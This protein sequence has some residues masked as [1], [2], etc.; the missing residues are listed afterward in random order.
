MAEMGRYSSNLLPL[1]EHIARLHFL[2]SF[3]IRYRH[4]MEF[5][6]ME[7]REIDLYLPLVWWLVQSLSCV[8]FRENPKGLLCISVK[9]LFLSLP[10]KK[11]WQ[12]I[13]KPRGYV[14]IITEIMPVRSRDPHQ[15]S[16]LNY[17]RRNKPLLWQVA[18]TEG[19]L[20]LFC[21]CRQVYF[22]IF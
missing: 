3:W 6:P 10:P 8:L 17:Y 18:G 21:S 13:S 11:M 20:V 5:Q 19:I 1:F 14:T 12:K 4:E 7:C 15:Q 2:G 9:P 22:L 16:T